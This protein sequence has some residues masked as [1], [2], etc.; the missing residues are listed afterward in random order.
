MKDIKKS[1]HGKWPLKRPENNGIYWEHAL[2]E[3]P[4][5]QT[6]RINSGDYLLN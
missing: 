2:N 3:A 5:L 4:D 1:K 6:F